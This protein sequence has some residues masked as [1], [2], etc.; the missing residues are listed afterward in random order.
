M[1]TA[2]VQ[3]AVT[4]K[5]DE[6]SWPLDYDYAYAP[7]SYLIEATIGWSSLDTSGD[8]AEGYLAAGVER[9]TLPAR[10]DAVITSLYS[11]NKLIELSNV[12]VRAEGEYFRIDDMRDG[13]NWGYLIWLGEKPIEDDFSFKPRTV[14]HWY[15][16]DDSSDEHTAPR[17][18]EFDDVVALMQDPAA[19]LITDVHH[20]QKQSSDDPKVT[21][22]LG[23]LKHGV[24]VWDLGA[25]ERHM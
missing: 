16:Y 25:I 17:L 24:V 14:Y 22:T 8:G 11:T 13:H 7:D 10:D 4:E 6:F 2:T 18:E 3:E 21:A 9:S 12:V 5:V 23:D 1:A 19:R 15:A 20:L